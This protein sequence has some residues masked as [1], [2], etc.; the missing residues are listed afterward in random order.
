M[1]RTTTQK[2]GLPILIGIGLLQSAG[3]AKASPENYDFSGHMWLKL[4]YKPSN[5]CISSTQSM[6]ETF[7]SNIP[8]I[9][10]IPLNTIGSVLSPIV[11]KAENFA[12]NHLEIPIPMD[13]SNVPVEKNG[14][15]ISFVIDHH[16]NLGNVGYFDI[17]IPMVGMIDQTGHLT[18]S[19]RGA[20]IT[21]D[22]GPHH[23][24]ATQT[25]GV[26]AIGHAD[27]INPSEIVPTIA[28]SPEGSRPPFVI[29]GSLK[30]FGHSCLPFQNK[31]GIATVTLSNWTLTPV[32]QLKKIKTTK[33]AKKPSKP[34]SLKE[35]QIEI[36]P[37]EPSSS[38]EKGKEKEIIPETKEP[39][40]VEINEQK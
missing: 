8:N 19:A 13:V 5:G 36:L 31:M 20:N 18:L 15:T 14:S 40:T 6:T 33:T 11:G 29:N 25:K 32:N 12:L 3:M 7:L 23:L 30:I 9:E 26:P 17:N 35:T 10:M 22:V 39:T 34:S 21:M 1:K 27:H 37:T 16:L 28:S 4:Q 2:W 24:T 38:N